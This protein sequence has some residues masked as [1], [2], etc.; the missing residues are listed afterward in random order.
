MYKGDIPFNP[1]TGDQVN[2]PYHMY[3]WKYQGV[4][5][6]SWMEVD[7]K[8]GKDKHKDGERVRINYDWRPNVPFKT[9]MEIRKTNRGRSAA[10]FTLRDDAS[11]EYTIFMV[12]L[13]E[14]L[15][16]HSITKGWTEELTWS[17]CKKGQ[18]YGVRLHDEQ[19]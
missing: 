13:L 5:Y 17:F 11:K 19:F 2:Y 1:Q 15:Q 6:S 16:K 9:K 18:N 4:V 7:R 12:D 14:V 8:L 3:G 10:N